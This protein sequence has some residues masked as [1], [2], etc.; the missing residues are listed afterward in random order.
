MFLL[1]LMVL[2]TANVKAQVRI[3]GNGVPNAAAVLDL[4]T[5]DTNSGTKGLALPRVS[6]S[7]VSTP[8]IGTPAVNGM[9]VYNTNPATVGGNG[10]GIYSWEG[11]NW[12]RLDIP[13]VKADSGKFLQSNGSAWVP[14]LGPKQWDTVWNN[15]ATW[16]FP[17]IISWPNKW[18][19]SGAVCFWTSGAYHWGPASLS[20]DHKT[21]DLINYSGSDNAM[22]QAMGMACLVTY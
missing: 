21:L 9:V 5:D 20:R 4:N 7:N 13:T 8:L 11:S 16:V 19:Y 14:S 10:T 12:V 3:G 15:S 17:S 2:G 1:L 6:L 22:G 18:H